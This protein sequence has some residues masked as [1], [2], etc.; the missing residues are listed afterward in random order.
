MQARLYPSP[1]FG[2]WS[3]GLADL[4]VPLSNMGADAWL[5]RMG[6]PSHGIARAALERHMRLQLAASC[7][8]KHTSCPRPRRAG[9]REAARTAVYAVAEWSGRLGM[10][11][12]VAQHATA[13]RIVPSH[14]GCFAP[15]GVRSEERTLRAVSLVPSH[16]GAVIDVE[17]TGD[18]LDPRHGVGPRLAGLGENQACLLYTSPSPRD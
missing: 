6:A 12:H 14:D 13:A 5:A 10:M 2:V 3:A 11:R 9:R 17:R 16:D 1:P 7:A 18:A 8:G 4:L 15:S